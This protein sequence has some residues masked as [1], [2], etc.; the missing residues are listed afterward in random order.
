VGVD[1]P[2]VR[3]FGNPYKKSG[4]GNATI[5]M[6]LSFSRSKVKTMFVLGKHKK[7]IKYKLNNYSGNTKVDF[8]IH[9]PPFGRHVSK[10]YKI[11]YF[12]WEASSL[13][14]PWAKDIRN[15][16]D[17]LWVPCDLTRQAC[18]KAGFKGPLEI[19]HTPCNSDTL[20]KRV[21]I[22]SSSAAGMVLSDNTFKFYSIF[23]WNNRK[24]Y[25][26]LLRAYF[27][28]FSDNDDVVLILKV[29]PLGDG[30]N[31]VSKIKSDIIKAKR[32]ANKRELPKIF[33][34]TR[35]IEKDEMLG[36][37]SLCDTFVLPHHGE[38][39]GMPIHDAML[40]DSNII[41]TKFGG[42]TELLNDDNANII[43][44]KI[45]PVQGMGWNRLY[46]SGQS[47]AN[48]SAAHLAIL[49]RESFEGRYDYSI[50]KENAKR[51]ATSLSIETCSSQIERIL[52]KNR[53]KR[54]L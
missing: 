13:P 15:N 49:M 10:N 36:L 52:S 37:H 38:G 28:E 53:F 54:F 41:T 32:M 25:R 31:G 46:N 17:E 8:Y 43:K 1:L 23:Q 48:P 39:W 19:L 47:W 51:I 9:T 26:E 29:N 34:I 50:K 18:L 35:Y 40:C 27:A 3:F 5:N 30:K 24:G 21:Q 2:A 22:P 45:G 42:I 6:C 7:D 12:Y 20:I 44:H 33:L 11:G 14:A 4:Y 16:V